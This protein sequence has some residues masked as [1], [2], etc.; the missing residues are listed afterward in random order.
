MQPYFQ[1]RNFVS[2]A[3][4]MLVCM[5]R[6]W[7]SFVSLSSINKSC[8]L[9]QVI[10]GLQFDLV[11][12]LIDVRHDST[13]I[14]LFVSDGTKPLVSTDC[15]NENNYV[16]TVT[17]QNIPLQFIQNGQFLY[18]HNVHAR[19]VCENRIKFVIEVD[20][21][22]ICFSTLPF[23]DFDVCTIKDRLC[24]LALVP[25]SVTTHPYNHCKFTAISDILLC[26]KVPNT[27]RINAIAVSIGL[28][29]VE[30]CVRLICY[31][32]HKKYEIPKSYILAL[33]TV[34]KPG[35]KCCNCSKASVM[36][37]YV[38]PLKVKDNT[39][40]MTIFLA[41][42]WAEK[43]FKDIPPT[44]LYLDSTSKNNVLQCLKTVFG[45]NPF[46]PSPP[47]SKEPWLDCHICSYYVHHNRETGSRPLVQYQITD[48]TLSM[49]TSQI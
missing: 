13:S 9:C 16:Q 21:R 36:Y 29:A 43:F 39:G 37:S 20:Q 46:E 17:V 11:C 19:P 31:H 49:S 12:K 18:L 25:P 38:V 27:Y 24:G 5:L 34:N 48:T 22:G 1:S 14:L 33:P 10:P 7:A 2:F 44:N 8:K 47:C 4:V 30:E 40:S 3:N 32:C 41:Y 23:T 35:S 45:R 26:S 6:K 28:L 15:C 42:Q